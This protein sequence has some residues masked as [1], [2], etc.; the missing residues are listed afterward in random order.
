M[1]RI[2]HHIIEFVPPDLFRFTVVGD[3][4]TAEGLE[5]MAYV[6]RHGASL[7]YVLVL[8]DVSRAGDVPASVRK[9]WA[10]RAAN[11]HICGSAM[12]GASFRTRLFVTMFEGII[13]LF[14]T[15]DNPRHFVDTEAQ[16]LAWIEARRR[17]LASPRR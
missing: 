1:L 4:S 16:A 13:R 12:L 15:Q 6:E 17:A 2:G 11:V 5:I 14:T 10:E 3:V 7:P 8:S 9:H